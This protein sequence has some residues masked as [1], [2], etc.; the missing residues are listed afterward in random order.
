ME[1]TGVE[2]A[3]EGVEITSGD[4][5][6]FM[7]VT[8]SAGDSKTEEAAGEGINA[9]ILHFGGEGKEAGGGS[10]LFAHKVAGDLSFD[11]LVI[12][13]ILIEGIDDPVAVAEGVWIGVILSGIE[14]VVGV[15]GDIEPVAAPAFAIA[16]GGEQAV[17][18]VF[19]GTRGAVALEGEDLFDGGWQAREIEE[20]A[21]D[22][23]AAAGGL[24]DSEP[25]LFEAGEDEA[26]DFIADRDGG[27]DGG[28]GGFF[29][30]LKA[31]PGALFGGDFVRGGGGHSADWEDGAGGD[32]IGEEFDIGFGELAGGGHLEL[33]VSMS[34]DLNEEARFGLARGDGGAAVAA[35]EQGLAGVEAEATHGR[36]G[37]ATVAILGEQGADLHLEEFGGI[38]RGEPESEKNQ[39]CQLHAHNSI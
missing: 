23:S 8:L 32:P 36:G 12:G 38:L 4:G 15:A 35:F 26:V 27:L 37:M 25:F 19:P 33:V 20:G 10:P 17:D 29:D 7:V 3:L 39:S 9:L 1:F 2:D 21:A 14:L 30:G 31:P 22:E 11:E 13:Q 5:I 18:D 6:E 34:D 16:G 28:W 24:G